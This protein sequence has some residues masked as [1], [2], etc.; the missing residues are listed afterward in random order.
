LT[1]SFRDTSEIRPKAKSTYLHKKSHHRLSGSTKRAIIQIF[2]PAFASDTTSA[3]QKVIRVILVLD[4]F[5]T[6]VVF[7]EKYVLEIWF[8]GVGLE[9]V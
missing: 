6:R 4:G 5:Q 8:E 7:A 9:S 1:L 3:P 2:D